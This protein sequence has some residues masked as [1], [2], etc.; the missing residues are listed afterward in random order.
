[1]ASTTTLQAVLLAATVAYV[2]YRQL[3]KPKPPAPYPPGPKPLP[4]IGNVADLTTRELWLVAERWAKE[5]GRITY[6]HVFGQGLVFLNTPEAVFELLDKRGAIYSDKPRLVMAG[7]L[8]GC[9]N[10]VAFTPYGDR[11]RRQRKL[12]Q[13]ALGPSSIKTYQPLLELETKPFLRRLVADPSKYQDHIRQYAGGL[14]LLVVYGHQAKSIDDPF[15]RLAEECVSL[16]SNRIASGGG[17]WPVDV[18]PSLKRLPE[19]FPGAGFKRNAA[20]WKKKM[21]EFVD[22]PYEFV[23]D[24]MDKGIA[25]SS[26]VSVLL[27]NVA[28]G[29]DKEVDPQ[30]DFDVRWTANSMYGASIDTT[31]ATISHFI[32]AMV[33]HPEVLKRAQAEVDAVVGPN[34]LPVCEDRESLPYCDAIF[35]ETLR[36]GVPLPLTLPH[37]LMEDDIYDDMFI[38]KGSIVRYIDLAISRDEK[39][40]PDPYSFNPDRYFH[41]AVDEAT[42]RRRDPRMYIFGFGRRR[43]PGANLVESSAWL[44]MVSVIATL[45]IGKAID[46]QG[47]EIEPEVV[48]DNAI[49]RSPNPFKCSIRPR[50]EHA[51]KVL[52][53]EDV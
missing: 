26:F 16:L 42:A 33:Q 39:L 7:E 25:R 1:M 6:L 21:E 38:P 36:W 12:M 53:Q 48:F 10:M 51:L 9:E 4:I 11:S 5:Y 40:Y 35:S 34:R 19:W 29:K 15:L 3:T 49:F 44:L 22:K 32:L 47:R 31:I 46:D 13:I 8:C 18:F 2:V 14:T 27:D 20:I 52:A 23:L 17:I 28:Q 45:D 24:E 41:P 37:R 50:S 30:L 43:C